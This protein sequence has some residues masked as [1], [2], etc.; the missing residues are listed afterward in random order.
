M[1]EHFYK[2]FTAKD[3]KTFVKEDDIWGKLIRLKD[4]DQ[5]WDMK[6]RDNMF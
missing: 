6:W 5:R 2:G 3:L 4:E 1:P